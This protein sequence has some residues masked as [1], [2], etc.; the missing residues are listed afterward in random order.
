MPS[1]KGAEGD[2]FQLQ[3]FY[4]T[5]SDNLVGVTTTDDVNRAM[6]NV[7]KD[8]NAAGFEL[9][10][11]YTYSTNMSDWLEKACF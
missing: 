5:Y 9:S 4:K 7:L 2:L 1:P 3:R 10:D 8:L 11:A 6:L